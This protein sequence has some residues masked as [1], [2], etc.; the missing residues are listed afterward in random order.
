MPKEKVRQVLSKHLEPIEMN[1][2][3]SVMPDMHIDFKQL[4]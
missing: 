4:Q 2:I 1:R 3:L